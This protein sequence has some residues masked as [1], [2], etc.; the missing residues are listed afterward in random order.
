MGRL[1]LSV[2]ML[3]RRSVRCR[4]FAFRF[5]LVGAGLGSK[6]PGICTG[7]LVRGLQQRLRSGAQPSTKNQRCER[8][9]EREREREI[10]RKRGH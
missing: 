4:S 10:E 7:S 9:R 1:L 3:E 5:T 6:S 8:E 2:S